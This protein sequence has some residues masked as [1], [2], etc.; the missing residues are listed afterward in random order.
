MRDPLTLRL[1]GLEAAGR[2][3]PAGGA[4]GA[5]GVGLHRG[6]FA[7]PVSVPS[8]YVGATLR[9]PMIHS[10]FGDHHFGSVVGFPY[11]RDFDWLINL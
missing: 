2:D 1:A 8:D 5:A 6:Q 7:L 11:G 3:P 4:A 9:R 10:W